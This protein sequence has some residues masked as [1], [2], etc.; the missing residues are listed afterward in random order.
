MFWVVLSL[1]ALAAAVASFFVYEHALIIA[2]SIA[3]SYAFVR[4]ISLFA[5]HYPNE[6]TLLSMIEKGLMSEI[7]PL[8]YA[9]LAGMVV[10]ALIGIF[11]Q[12]RMRNKEQDLKRHPYFVIR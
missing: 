1:F 2:S 7:D 3:G 5:G 9:Y 8:F 12:Y 10:F 6:F 11:V 4:G